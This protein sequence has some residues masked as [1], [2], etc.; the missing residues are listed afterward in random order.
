MSSAA[1]DPRNPQNEKTTLP[2]RVIEEKPTDYMA[3]L[4]MLCGLFGMMLKVKIGSWLAVLF[5]LSAFFNNR[6]TEGDM[7]QIVTTSLFSVLGLFMNY[8]GPKR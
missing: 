3:M 2:E 7:K 8:F 4:A 1:A 5:C 6:K